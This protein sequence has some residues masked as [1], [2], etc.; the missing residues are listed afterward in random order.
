VSAGPQPL[1]HNVGVNTHPDHAAVAET[2]RSWYTASTPEIGLR[3]DQS[4]YG[5]VTDG[6]SHVGARVVVTVDS[7]VALG[8]ALQE[9]ARLY[10]AVDIT[11]WVDDRDR[12]ARLHETLLAAGC[13]AGDGNTFLALVGPVRVDRR[14]GGVDIE[15]I[16]VDGLPIWA[17]V[18]LQ[19]F[20]DSE[21]PPDPQALDDEVARR[22]AEAPIARYELATQGG[23]PVAV[24]GAYAGG[25]DQMVFNLATRMPYRHQGIAQAMLAGWAARGARENCR[26]LLI[27]GMDG[28][29]PVQLYQRL[30]FVDEVYWRRTYAWPATAH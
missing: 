3:I 1:H 14:A 8:D 26:S 15:E 17:T 28:G 2:V 30:G 13:V 11:V 22:R 21:E 5:F 7:P 20:A 25:P 27:N 23:E 10:G 16:G 9:I 18:K 12:A 24:L 6:A 19:G 4:W 29:P